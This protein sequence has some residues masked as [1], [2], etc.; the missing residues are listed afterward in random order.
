MK[1]ISKR[2][3]SCHQTFKHF[4]KFICR[5]LCKQFFSEISR[6]PHFSF[7]SKSVVHHMYA[8]HFFQ[9]IVMIFTLKICKKNTSKDYQAFALS[10]Q[11]VQSARLS[12]QSSELGTPPLT[13]KGVLLLPH[14]SPR[15][16]TPYTLAGGSTQFRRR[17]IHSGTLCIL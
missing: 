4:I 10:L 1:N 9:I 14:L 7:F 12:L 8:L 2:V 3:A 11:N 16:E 13:L 15:G 5:N 17:D 6:T